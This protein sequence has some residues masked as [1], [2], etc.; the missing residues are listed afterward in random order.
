MFNY[1]TQDND[2]ICGPIAILNAYYRCYKKYPFDKTNRKY[3]INSINE[4]CK[5]MKTS[6]KGT[7]I[8]NLLNCGIMKLGRT[9]R[10]IHNI[11][12]LKR[13]ILMY[14]FISENRIRYHLVFVEKNNENH[15]SIYN[16]DSCGF[17]QNLNK[18]TFYELYLKDNLIVKHKS[19]IYQFPMAWEV[20][21]KTL[22]KK[23]DLTFI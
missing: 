12:H 9:R 5:I 19:K 16:G 13:F 20:K 2:Y 11:I 14:S 22:Y 23:S 6:H 15:Y 21:D 4:L 10:N 7:R 18:Q 17:Y 3:P 8:D 1:L